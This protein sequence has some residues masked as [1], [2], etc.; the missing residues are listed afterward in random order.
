MKK[1]FFLTG[2]AILLMAGCDKS[3][4]QI[5]IDGKQNET[6]AQIDAKEYNADFKNFALAVNK[7]LVNSQFRDVIKK[8]ALIKFDGDYD[9]IISRVLDKKIEHH[10]SMLKSQNPNFS[11]RD[12][13]DESFPHEAKLKSS[14]SSIIDELSAKYPDLQVAIPVHAEDWD[15]E[16]Y[17]PVVTFLP[18]EFEDYV[19]ETLTGYNADGSVTAVD[20]IN[21]P[22]MPVIVV[23][24]N[25]RIGLNKPMDPATPTEPNYPSHEL[26]EPD[27]EAPLTPTNLTAVQSSEGVVLNW[28]KNV[29]Q[30]VGIVGYYIYRKSTTEANFDVKDICRGAN[31]TVYFDVTTEPDKTYYYYVE[32]YNYFGHSEASNTVSIKGTG[33]PAAITTFDATLNTLNEVEL[34]WTTENNQ[35][36]Q[37]INLYKHIVGETSGYQLE[38]TFTTNEY[39]YFDHNIES[40]TTINYRMQ[41]VTPTGAS[42]PKYDLI[43]VPYRDPSKKSPVRIKKIQCSSD[44]ESWARGVP[45]FHIKVLGVSSSDRTKQVELQRL[46]TCEFSGSIFNR[47]PWQ[48]VIWEQ[49]F[50]NLAHEWKPDLWYDV[51][52]FYVVES[53]KVEGLDVSLSAKLYYKK[54]SIAGIGLGTDNTLSVTYKFPNNGNEIGYYYLDYFDEKEK[55]LEFSDYKFKMLIS[56]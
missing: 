49:N 33:K 14:G 38:K 54:D 50:D 7:A 45:E 37:G 6:I 28:T 25:E 13:L 39:D 24:E 52:T 18:Y 5:N 11:V 31:N 42:N 16:N 29:K 15:E 48:E 8:E 35:Y 9:V 3:A 44:V 53:D 2:I 56:E 23:G 32:A 30:G 20:A 17:I 41:I 12:L 55:W 43:K 10:N 22:D 51:L 1:V 21:P 46:I 47:W 27:T 4:D 40:G 34:R 19:T 26:G 36:I